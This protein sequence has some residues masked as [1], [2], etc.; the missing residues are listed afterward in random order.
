MGAGAGKNKYQVGEKSVRK[1][2]KES[3]G[4]KD[5]GGSKDSLDS[6]DSGLDGIAMP[7]KRAPSS[8]SDT[9]S[10]DVPND[11]EDV[12]RKRKVTGVRPA[13][14][15]TRQGLESVKEKR[16]T[17]RQ[18]LLQDGF[19]QK[20]Y[21]PDSPQ[22][23]KLGPTSTRKD[24]ENACPRFEGGNMECN[25]KMRV[26]HEELLGTIHSDIETRRQIFRGLCLRCHLSK[27]DGVPEEWASRVH[28]HLMAQREWYLAAEPVLS[29]A[30]AQ[31][32]RR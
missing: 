6:K 23:P 3:A 32:R 4:S 25:T 11:S 22:S 15:T 20:R 19:V 30:A 5:S 1:G 7:R 18:A 26:A 13:R 17:T 2:S 24:I 28:N 16:A 31:Q 10:T 14:V 29:P 27:N 12:A 8:H 21:E 9:C